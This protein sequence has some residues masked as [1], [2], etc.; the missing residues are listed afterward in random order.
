MLMQNVISS[1]IV[2]IGYDPE[3]MRLAIRFRSGEVYT[4]MNV[5]HEVYDG[6]MSATSKGTYHAQYIKN[7]YPY[8]R[9]V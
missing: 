9:G 6:I 2:G 7:V 5:P 4:Y 1:N 8:K 3:T